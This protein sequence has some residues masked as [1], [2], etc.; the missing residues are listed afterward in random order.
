MT[1]YPTLE[2]VEAADTPTLARWSRHLPSPGQHAIGQDDF[3]DVLDR[4]VVISER[5][6]ARFKEAGGWTPSLSK[7]VGW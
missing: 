7:A 6:S 5:I 2:Q 4:E 1:G 3:H